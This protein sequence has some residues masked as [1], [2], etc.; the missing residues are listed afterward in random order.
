MSGAKRS[1]FFETNPYL[2]TESLHVPGPPA[3][4]SG[5]CLSGRVDQGEVMFKGLKIVI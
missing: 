5:N 4:G 3:L 1:D 2:T